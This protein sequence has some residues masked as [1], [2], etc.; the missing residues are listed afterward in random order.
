MPIYV[1]DLPYMST[2]YKRVALP[3]IGQGSKNGYGSLVFLFTQNLTQSIENINS[4]NCYHDGKYRDYYY[5][6]KYTGSIAGRRYNINDIETRKNVYKQIEDRTTVSPHPLIAINKSPNRNCY[7]DLHKYL[8]IYLYMTKKYGFGKK[9][10]VFWD[11][12]NSIWNSEESSTFP[13]KIVLINVNHFPMN[14]GQGMKISDKLN[15]P[16]FLLY[17]TLYKRFDLISKLNIDIVIFSNKAVLKINPSKCDEK[18]YLIVNRELKKILSRKEVT[19]FDD[20]NIDEES[21]KELIKDT[22]KMQYN[23]TGNN[24]DNDE[25]TEIKETDK[26]NNSDDKENVQKKLDDKIDAAVNSAEIDVKNIVPSA[27]ISSSTELS[28]TIKAKSEMDIE[29]DEELIKNMYDF[30]KKEKVPTKPLSTARDNAMRTRQESLKMGT[31]SFSDLKK[32]DAAK[33]SV[34][35]KDISKSVKTI[36]PNMKSVKFNNINKDYIE[37]VMPSDMMKAFTSLNSKDM[38]LY[39]RDVKI[40]DS[41]DELNYKETYHVTLEDEMKQRHSVTVDIPKF[42][43]NKFLYVGGNKKTI[44]RQNFLYP[45]VKTGPSTVQI[46]T[47]YNKVF[48]RR[49]GTKSISSVERIMKMIS[50]DDKMYKYFIAGNNSSANNGFLTSIEYDE[51]AKVLTKFKSDN[52]EIFFNQKEA[53]EFGEKKFNIDIPIDNGKL[54]FIGEYK[55]KMLVI[56]SDTQLVTD[57]TTDQFTDTIKMQDNDEDN[58][59]NSEY[60]TSGKSI[61]DIIIYELPSDMQSQYMKTRSTK[62]LMYNT[63]TI[64]GQ[65][66]PLIVLLLFWEGFSSVIKKIGLKYYFSAKYPSNV[67]PSESVIRFSDSYFVYEEDLPT[68]LLMNG[69]RLLDTENYTIEDYNTNEPY[70]DFFVKKYGKANIMNAIYN[71]YEF[72]IDP[73]TL[74]ILEDINLPT[75]IIELFIYANNLLAD[76]SYTKENS[77]TLSRVRSLEIIPAILY[78]E[79]SQAYLEYKNSAGKKKVTLPKNCVIKQLMALQT[80]EDYST[81][82]PVVEL[83]KDRVI[84]SKGYRGINLER[85]YTE[86]KRSY[87]KS[88]IGTI[89]MSTSPDGNCGITRFLTM[90]PNITSARG[91][92]NIKENNID[93]L[94]DVNLFSP[95]ELLYPL[96]NTRDDSI[97]IAIKTAVAI[98]KPL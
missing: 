98:K 86:E 24:E 41:S 43:E 68:S 92:V 76:E 83:E 44:N 69:I 19:D 49:L 73:I 32:M 20:A 67:K 54:I 23:F 38:K 35:T 47:N 46:V 25:V 8:E 82:N 71:Y 12:F 77:Q 58:S 5:N 53:I 9:L 48:I 13:T 2:Q 36:N 3:R 66:I 16:L 33:R 63:A 81:L 15:N 40:E 4:K 94:K 28:F 70:I 27:E 96:G 97:R 39:V 21:R 72:L 30:M 56:D 52:C 31:V 93:D 95:A 91:Y 78:S 42:L 87:D 59:E 90:E 64:M 74:E 29:N 75:D 45:V 18:S 26:K 84:T 14:N 57:M 50:K 34:P 89:A 1:N 10:Q 79:L 61:S 62:K 6:G 7:F 60:T 22:L 85:A 65:A 88:M 51:F 11:F 80:V 17:F 55:G 37:N